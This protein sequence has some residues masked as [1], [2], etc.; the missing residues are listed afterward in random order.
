M[1]HTSKRGNEYQWENPYHPKREPFKLESA[2][3]AHSFIHQL[4]GQK[5]A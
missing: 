1:T 4:F 5:Q 2:K 3:A